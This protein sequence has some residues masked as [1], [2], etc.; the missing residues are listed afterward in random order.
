MAPRAARAKAQPG[1]IPLDPNPLQSAGTGVPAASAAGLSQWGFGLGIA[2]GAVGGFS[3]VSQMLWGV[4]KGDPRGVMNG[5]ANVTVAAST[6]AALGVVGGAALMA[7]LGTVLLASRGLHSLNAQKRADRLNGYGDLA[8]AGAIASKVMHGPLGLTFGFGFAAIG[9]DLCK[10]LN[11]LKNA[12]EKHDPTLRIRGT[13]GV[14]SSIGVG[15][16]AAG[17]GLAPGLGLILVGVTLPLLERVPVLRP[18][19]DRTAQAADW[20]LY[21]VAHGTDRAAHYAMR[22]LDPLLKPLGRA[23]RSVRQTLPPL[24]SPI[25]KRVGQAVHGTLGVAQKGLHWIESRRWFQR[26]DTAVQRLN[27]R[28]LPAPTR[29]EE[30][31]AIEAAVP[32]ASSTV[33]TT[34]PT[35]QA[36]SVEQPSPSGD[37]T[38]AESPGLT[39][40]P[41][42]ATPHPASTPSAK[43]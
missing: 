10:G 17:V 14:L 41:S 3:G 18:A 1:E 13:G 11:D 42:D 27:E 26:L 31:A 39:A 36:T 23:M 19:I 28:L 38:T 21:P 16:V 29:E 24:T 4:K 5:A 22:R 33:P 6:L 12:R 34:A 37:Q 43:S 20:L 32:P 9:I 2:G 40:A 8:T 7:P 15:M 25:E 30:I 35:E